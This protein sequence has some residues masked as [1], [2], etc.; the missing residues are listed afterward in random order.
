MKIMEIHGSYTY[1]HFWLPHQCNITF[2]NN[3]DSWLSTW[4]IE[5]QMT[6]KIWGQCYKTFKAVSYKF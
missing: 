6:M 4:M 5:T 1:T 3:I 2:L